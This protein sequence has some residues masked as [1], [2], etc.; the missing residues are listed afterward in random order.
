MVF[1]HTQLKKQ[2]L[3][4]NSKGFTLAELVVVI[5]IFSIIAGIIL[6]NHRSFSN[7]ATTN[8]VAQEMALLVRKAQSY[9]LGLQA[10]GLLATLPV[11]GYG[12]RFESN[13]IDRAMF[14]VELDPDNQYTS[15]IFPPTCGAPNSLGGVT[16]ECI[17]YALINSNDRI[18]NIIVDGEI[19]KMSDPAS[20]VD[21]I[22][23]K[24]SGDVVFCVHKFGSTCSSTTATPVGVVD[25]VIVSESGKSKSVHIYGNGQISVE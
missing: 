17:E 23:K 14:F 19:I 5:G 21:I 25:I 13:L 12:V 1:S 7:N 4:L 18:D 20:A 8:N 15:T 24:P 22:F 10:P 16:E 6:F 3:F 2:K 11:R 9:S